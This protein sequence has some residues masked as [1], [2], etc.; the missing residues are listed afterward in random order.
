MH[1]ALP[2]SGTNLNTMERGG[3]QRRKLKYSE[4]CSNPLVGWKLRWNKRKVSD[5]QQAKTREMGWDVGCRRERGEMVRCTIKCHETGLDDDVCLETF[6]LGRARTISNV[7]LEDR[8][9]T[10]G[11]TVNG[12]WRRGGSVTFQTLSLSSPTQ[13]LKSTYKMHHQNSGTCDFRRLL[14]QLQGFFP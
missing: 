14:R 8:K 1:G 12:M 10:G 6:P 7:F 11:L 4:K 5:K 9:G 2:E 13:L 3:K